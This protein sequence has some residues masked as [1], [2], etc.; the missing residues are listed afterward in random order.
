MAGKIP[1]RSARPGL[2]EYGRT[3]LH[4]A[5]S[6]AM[7]EEVAALIAQGH[8]PN[9]KDDNGWT[10]LHFAAQSN[11]SRCVKILLDAGADASLVDSNGNSPLLRAVFSSK[12]DGAVIRE[13][14][15]A[16]ADPMQKNLSGVSPISL[17][18]T[19]ANYPVAQF[20]SDVTP[21]GE[22]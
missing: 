7:Y 13:L 11:A 16:G 20:F 9:A 3:P 19:I 5:A 12:G 22:R 14:R 15:A 18:A 10:P 2:D 4:Y 17:A 8:N 21:P 6:D 1:K